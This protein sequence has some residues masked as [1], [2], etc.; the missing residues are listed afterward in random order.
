[1]KIELNFL[2]RFFLKFSNIEFN[3]HPSCGVTE[4]F[5]YGQTDVTE[6]IGA[7]RN[8]ASPPIN[9]IPSLQ[10]WHC[11]SWNCPTPYMSSRRATVVTS[12]CESSFSNTYGP[13][14]PVAGSALTPPPTA[15]SRIRGMS[16]GACYIGNLPSLPRDHTSSPTYS[17]GG[18]NSNFYN[19]F[20]LN[21]LTL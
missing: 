16:A 1:M 18:N 20:C 9:Y 15:A 8:F 13:T 12:K 3:K 5:S 2:D 14:R 6:L 17:N 11:A 19:Y 4:F 10:N 7:F 21:L